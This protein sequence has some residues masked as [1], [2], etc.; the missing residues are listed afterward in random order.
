MNISKE[1]NKSHETVPERFFAEP[2]GFTVG[3]TAAFATDAFV[4]VKTRARCLLRK[5][6]PA[7]GDIWLVHDTRRWQNG[8]RSVLSIIISHCICK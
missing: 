5:R 3:E 7:N 1:K 4:R 2:K 6:G 8:K